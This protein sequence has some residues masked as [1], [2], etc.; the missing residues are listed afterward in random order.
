M[1][2]HRFTRLQ[3]SLICAALVFVA[4]T[5]TWEY[6]NGGV[7]NHYLLHNPDYPSISNYWGLLILPLLTWF[8]TYRIKTGFHSQM[9]VLENT[10]IP[11]HIRRG[12]LVMCAV[13]AAQSVAWVM[14]EP[15]ITKYL[16]IAVILTGIFI[17]IYHSHFFLANVLVSS[18]IFGSVIP[19]IGYAVIALVSAVSNLCIKPL[20]ISLLVRI[21]VM[22]VA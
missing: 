18:V 12:F 13:T 5:L 20:I 1:N 8:T 11:K 7:K 15:E 3:I 10:L 22:K 19:L 17:P 4:A 9:G 6:F 14:G 16:A 21:K 2:T